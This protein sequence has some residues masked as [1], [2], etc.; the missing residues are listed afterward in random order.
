MGFGAK[1]DAAADS[2][3]DAGACVLL[4]VLHCLHLRLEIA[5]KLLPAIAMQRESYCV[6]GRCSGAGAE[7][8]AGAGAEDSPGADDGTGADNGAGAGTDADDGASACASAGTL[9]GAGLALALALAVVP[10]PPQTLWRQRLHHGASALALACCA[11]IKM[12]EFL[13]D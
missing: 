5:L 11:S 12:A 13:D 7:D 10:K 9:A 8:G 1:A 6:P 3:A 4:L 2:V